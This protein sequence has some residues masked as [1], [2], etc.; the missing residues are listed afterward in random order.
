[1]RPSDTVL[2]RVMRSRREGRQPK[3]VVNHIKADD[4]PE[5]EALARHIRE[6]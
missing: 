4:G 2:R 3:A 1:M 6:P 5:F